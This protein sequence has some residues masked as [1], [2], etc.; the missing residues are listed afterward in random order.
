[1]KTIWKFPLKSSHY[2]V[3]M[4]KGAKIVEVASQGKDLCIWAIVEPDALVEHRMFHVIGTG[5]GIPDGKLSY[6]GT[7]HFE[8]TGLV[9]HVFEE[10]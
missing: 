1:M 5:F 2:Q 6:V 10:K 7:A 8:D 4:P 3:G 9:F